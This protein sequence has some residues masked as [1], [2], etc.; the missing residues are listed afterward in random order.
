MVEPSQPAG[1]TLRPG[2]RFYSGR[3]AWS[4]CSGRRLWG[5]GGA[6]GRRPG[7][8]AGHVQRAAGRHLASARRLARVDAAAGG[9]ATPG[10]PWTVGP[11]RLAAPGP[12]AIGVGPVAWDKLA[13]LRRRLPPEGRR[14]GG[15]V[16][17][18]VAHLHGMEGV[19]GSN[20]L[21]STY[22]S[23]QTRT[24]EQA[25]SGLDAPS[26]LWS[27]FLDPGG[28]LVATRSSRQRASSNPRGAVVWPAGLLGAGGLPAPRRRLRTLAV[29]SP[30]NGLTTVR[31][32][33]G[34]LACGQRQIRAPQR[35][36][37]AARAGERCRL[38]RG[39][40]DVPLLNA[41]SRSITT[42]LTSARGL[43]IVHLDKV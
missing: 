10:D 8:G 31:V 7:G 20:P 13:E 16:A 32:L 3:R 23:T 43:K 14:R 17:Q 18:L 28:C 37:S 24:R 4:P 34:R 42:N 39:S 9:A 29:A 25:W 30:V 19:R 38:Q 22:S 21:S 40:A 6:A 35:S 11:E 5:D 27:S 2:P 1:P 15:A 26:E 12:G 33:H 41:P 36:R